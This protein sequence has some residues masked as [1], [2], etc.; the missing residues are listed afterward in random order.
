MG[1]GRRWQS[2]NRADHGQ[3]EA[4]WPVKQETRGR[5]KVL[6]Y[7]RHAPGL[8]IFASHSS[9]ASPCPPLPLSAS[10]LTHVALLG[11][12][13]SAGLVSAQCGTPIS[14]FPYDEGFEAAPGWASGG[15]ASDWTW[16][17]PAHPLINSAGGGSKSWCVGGLTGA[18]YNSNERSW[19]ESPCFD[20]TTLNAP[21]ISFKIFWEV[22]R[23][24]DGMTFQYSTDGGVTYANVGGY[25]EPADC[26]TAHWFNSANITNLPNTINPKHG[27]SGRVGATQGSCLGS[28]GSQGWVTASHCLGFLANEPSVRFRFF[29]GAGSTCNNFDGIAIDDIH[30]GESDPVVATFAGDCDGTTISFLNGSTPCPHLFSWNF[31]EPGSPQNTSAEENP[32]H[33]YAA[34]G[35]Y[36]VTLTATDACGATATTTQDISILGVAITTV[37]P[38]CG[39]DNG[40]LT[41]QVTGATGPVNYV[42]SPGGA[43]TQTLANAGPGDY[44][45]T[46]TA[47]NSCSATATATLQPSIDN[48]SVA[49]AH[50]DVACAGGADGTA[51]AEV[52]GGTAPITYAWSPVGG[53]T[54][55]ITGLAAGTYSCTVSDGS[56]CTVEQTVT[57]EEPEALTVAALPD[58][59]VCTGTTFIMQ[60]Q[61][62]GGVPGYTY[63]W[64]PEGPA[65]TPQA[66]TLYTVTATDANGCTS[67]PDSM[68]V[69]VAAAFVPSFTF[70]DPGGCSPHCISFQP[71]P[72]DAAGYL[73]D[74]G[75]GTSDTAPTPEHC[76]AEGGL[77]S[78][79]LTVFDD[80]GCA[81]TVS[82]PD[83]ADITASPVAG[84]VPSTHI[85][86]IDAPDVA[87]YNTSHNA[88]Q[89]F[90]T[91]GQGDTSMQASPVSS[92]PA[93]DCYT[94]TLEAMNALG[95]R[96]SVSTVICV[97]DPFQ[98]FLPN[99]FTPNADG[100][101]DLFRPITSVSAPEE[102]Q[103]LVFDRWGAQLFA[104]ED[105][106]RGWDGGV[107]PSG[108][109]V[110]K[111]KITDTL[112]ER[113]EFTGHVALV[114]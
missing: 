73:W 39:Q 53:T 38:S 113:H 98:L 8:P 50:T 7:Y 59:V 12:L 64:A 22:E 58:T 42:W 24:Y 40:S 31:G 91:F 30:I 103:M 69:Q 87:F 79:T 11:G 57:V 95:C 71:D 106:Q 1:W 66:S 92:F 70:S 46:V 52:A 75:D 62:G 83:L 56:G 32:S 19:L 34:P 60:A 48:L 13:V 41:A 84:F 14:T 63:T 107:H 94:V 78:V 29:F 100:I 65:V 86:T 97:E 90:W 47:A 61:A 28:G 76:Y 54:A 110:W 45:V 80:G 101:N 88:A 74:F 55:T 112:G 68:Q 77:F 36:T 85:T 104:T 109:Y 25:N 51:T 3:T 44:T 37:Q 9:M 99:A 102:F 105:L 72:P 15:T 43:T 18:Y 35:T 26:N 2:N 5:M 21:R 10:L 96:D 89:Y 17:T 16:G 82:V 33:T 49:M 81:G 108:I 93:V 23:Q 67:P 4:H 20:F 111:L 6:F 27:W 114:R